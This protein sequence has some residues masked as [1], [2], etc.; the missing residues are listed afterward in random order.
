MMRKKQKE[1]VEVDCSSTQHIN[2]GLGQEGS[3]RKEAKEMQVKNI[4]IQSC[5]VL[6][7]LIQT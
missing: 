2:E 6:F 1:Q 7:R 3:G 5:G 4:V